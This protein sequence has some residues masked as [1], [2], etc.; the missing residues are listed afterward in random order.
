MTFINT[1]YFFEV[2]AQ[3]EE[4]RFRLFAIERDDD[5]IDEPID[6]EER[7]QGVKIEEIPGGDKVEVIPLG[8][9]RDEPEYRTRAIP[10]TYEQHGVRIT[11]KSAAPQR[12]ICHRT[13][14]GAYSIAA[15]NDDSVR[16]VIRRCMREVLHGSLLVT[17]IEHP[18]HALAGYHD[19]VQK[20]VQDRGILLQG[21]LRMGLYTEKELGP[22]KNLAT[23]K[24]KAV[25]ATIVQHTEPVK[26]GGDWGA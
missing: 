14:F 7:F 23:K 26:D 15:S 17:A 6:P 22:W 4:K 25:K 19:L 5:E 18:G 9:I 12:R 24:D 8:G 13:L 10:H 2:D 20:A 11:I 16:E 3:G 21:P 1:S